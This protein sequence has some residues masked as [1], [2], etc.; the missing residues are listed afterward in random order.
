MQTIHKIINDSLDKTVVKRN[1]VGLVVTS[2]PYPMIEMWDECFKAQS[3]QV[4][5]DFDTNFYRT[6]WLFMHEVL[7]NVWNSVVNSV[8]DGGIVCINI[9]DATRSFDGKFQMYPNSTIISEYFI[10][11][12]FV[13]LP[14]I[15]WRKRTNAPNKFM[16]SGMYPAGAYVTL[17]HEHIL[18]FRKHCKREFNREEKEIRKRSAYF[19]S[20]RNE[21][22]SDLW[23][24]PGVSQKGIKGSRDRNGSY[25]LELPYRLI[26]MYSLQGDTVLDPFAGLGT[27]MIAAIMSGRNSYNFEIESVLCDYMKQRVSEVENWNS[28]TEKRLEKQKEFVESENKKGK[29]LYYNSKID[30]QVKTKQE[31]DLMLPFVDSV[32]IKDNIVV[33]YK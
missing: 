17:E 16:G 21:W 24:L 9:G 11:H 32:D 23:E 15:I 26:N 2:P 13:E 30:M 28:Y 4:K 19:Y 3:K 31:M 22:F 12:G 7:N 8:K 29:S 18:I 6:A 25:P 20:E 10:N 33:T 14:G 1:S 27:T 5:E